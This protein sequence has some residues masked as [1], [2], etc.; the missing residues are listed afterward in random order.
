MLQM[1]D[2]SYM[3]SL[4]QEQHFITNFV[5]PFHK[6]LPLYMLWGASFLLEL[7]LLRLPDLDLIEIIT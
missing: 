3:V 4:A 1:W 7:Y 5:V 6:M 2:H